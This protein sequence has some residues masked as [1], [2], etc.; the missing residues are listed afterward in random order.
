MEAATYI[1]SLDEL[2]KSFVRSLP[3][4]N[5]IDTLW[6]YFSFLR[7][8]LHTCLRDH[9]LLALFKRRGLGTAGSDD[10]SAKAGRD[11]G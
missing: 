9:I 1:G 2:V 7:D 8:F 6:L 11:G 10:R 4:N 5:S 3:P